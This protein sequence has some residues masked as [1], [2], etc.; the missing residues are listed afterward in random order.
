[1]TEFEVV[2][3]TVAWQGRLLQAGTETYRYADGSENTFD[4]VWHPGAVTVIALDANNVWLVRQPR[5]AARISD[6]LEIPAGKRDR[7]D[8]SLLELARRELVEEIGKEA[9]HWREVLSF[10][11]TPGFCDEQM[12][13]FVATDLSNTHGG[14]EPEA[15]EHIEVVAWPLSDLD[16][17]IAATTDAKTLIGLLWLARELQRS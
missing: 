16:S 10:H 4:K 9:G 17:A 8:E 13:M 5:E 2:A 14:P 1:V 15:D 7:P 6:S 3:E 12:T 11:P